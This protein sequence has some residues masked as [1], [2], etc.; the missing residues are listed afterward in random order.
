MGATVTAFEFPDHVPPLGD[1][2][3]KITEI[4]SLPVVVLVPFADETEDVAKIAFEYARDMTVDVFALRRRAVATLCHELSDHPVDSEFTGSVC[5]ADEPEGAPTI[6]LFGFVQDDLTLFHVTELALESL[7]G[8]PLE[9][10]SQA[11]R[12]EY[13][14]PITESELRQRQR[15][16]KRQNV[17]G[18]VLA[19]CTMP[20]VLPLGVVWSIITMPF[21]IWR[22]RRLVA[23]NEEGGA[24][25]T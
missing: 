18:L 23:K 5:G 24:K 14:L 22:D 2:C 11:T 10:I 16:K 3:A 7:G 4:C 21:T 9:P 12:N 25:T 8:T 17:G 6:S 20:I 13:T 1:I 19:I 15:R